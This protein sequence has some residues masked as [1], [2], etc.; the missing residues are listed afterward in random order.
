MFEKSQEEKVSFRVNTKKFELTKM[1]LHKLKFFHAFIFTVIYSAESSFYESLLKA[2]WNFGSLF[3]DV[4][5]LVKQDVKNEHIFANTNVYRKRYSDDSLYM[6]TIPIV[7]GEIDW[8]IIESCVNHAKLRLM[9]FGNL[10]QVLRLR[11]LDPI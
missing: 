10:S 9:T 3:Q 5:E 2:E 11:Y 4:L 8:E 1:Q 7:D 6:Y